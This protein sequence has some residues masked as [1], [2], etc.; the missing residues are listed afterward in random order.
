MNQVR[1]VVQ[2]RAD[3]SVKSL[4]YQQFQ[5][6]SILKKSNEIFIYLIYI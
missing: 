4:N 6:F 1:Q 5:Q 2:Q 3:Q